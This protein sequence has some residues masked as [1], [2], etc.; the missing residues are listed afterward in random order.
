MAVCALLAVTVGL[1][2][3]E[4][5]AC[6]DA[7]KLELTKGVRDGEALGVPVRLTTAALGVP[8]SVCDA[9]ALRQGAADAVLEALAGGE[10]AGAREALPEAH[11]LRVHINPVALP[12]GV[13]L[14]EAEALGLLKGEVVARPL[15]V[16]P[17]TGVAVTVA[18]SRLG[19]AVRTREP[20][21]Q[22]EAVVVFERVALLEHEAAALAV[23]D[24]LGEAVAVL[25]G[26]AVRVP[27]ALGLP[28][29]VAT[30]LREALGGA[31]AVFEEV[32]EAE[33][34]VV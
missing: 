31:E 3:P 2:G 28:V 26:E 7:E 21:A 25:V 29:F 19:L 8:L 33:G 4:R 34:L 20:V 13:E 24:T 23:F 10:G 14:D 30:A 5:V 1:R 9:E 18:L 12:E 17:P 27:E 15:R 32:P 22:G 16:A 11:A 6:S